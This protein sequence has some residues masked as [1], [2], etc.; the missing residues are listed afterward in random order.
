MKDQEDAGIQ[1][2]N[3]KPLYAFKDVPGKGKGLIA[4]TKI[5]R[6]T[7]ILCE[8]PVITVP[9]DQ[10]D[11]GRLRKIIYN[12][13]NSLSKH[14]KHAFLSMR[15]IHAYKSV[16]DQYLGIIRTNGL[17]IA[18]G[19]IES[20][21][22]LNACRINHACDNNAQKNWNESI[23]QHTV[24][25]LRDIDEGEEIT[26]YYLGIDQNRSA[27]QKSLRE[28]FGFVCSC[29]PCSLPSG[30]IQENDR[31]LDKI[32]RLDIIIGQRGLVGI[33]LYPLQTL[34]YVDEQVRLYNEIGPYD[35][36]LPRAFLDAAQISIA[37]GD[38]A[39]G[40]IFMERAVFGWRMALGND[41]PQVAEYGALAKDVSKHELYETS[42]KW[43][44]SVDEVPGDL[45]PEDFETWLWRR[46][47]PLR[48]GQLVSLRN[49]TI[50]PGFIDLPGEDIIDLNFY[51]S[52]DMISGQP[53]QHW[54]F[55]AEIVECTAL[56]RLQMLLKDIDGKKLP[57]FFYT[58][59][60]GKKFSPAQIQKGYTVAVLY[61]ERRAF[62]FDDP[63]I[64]VEDSQ[65]IKVS[66][67][68]ANSSK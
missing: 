59:D 22:F 52:N 24:H 45:P 18:V 5:S 21:I 3:E 58:N 13:V 55:L 49:R 50:F 10:W 35:T 60:R 41:S 23:Q 53:R 4:T 2:A 29:R 19:G 47:K 39:R 38:L 32:R 25:A 48:P 51:E 26:I 27:R 31:I 36:G 20:G 8:K 15:N 40:R 1:N 66:L 30:E 17:P 65:V 61:A 68:L 42:M 54:C 37:N 46:E 64:R 44:T 56:V 63:G 16:E 6:G 14:Q 62:K 7:R 34:R 33:V 11:I 28:K 67:T 57:L 43:K 12:Q 9:Q